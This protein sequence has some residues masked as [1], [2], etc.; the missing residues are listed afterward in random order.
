M[1]NGSF[2]AAHLAG[3]VN[4]TVGAAGAMLYDTSYLYVASAANLVSGKNW[5]RITLGSAY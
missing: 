5:R 4:G 3:G 2:G 1:A